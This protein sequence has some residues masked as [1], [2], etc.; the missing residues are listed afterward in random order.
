MPWDGSELWVGRLDTDGSVGSTDLIAGGSIG[1][2]REP[3]LGA[4]RQ[5]RVRL[6]PDRAGGTCIAGGRARPGI[7]ALCPMEA[8]FAVPQW[9]FG[10]RQFG[11]DGRGRVVAI[12]R[13]AGRDRL[14]VLESGT[15][16][17]SIA[18]GRDRPARPV[19]GR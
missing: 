4:R 2:H 14:L 6:G 16:R 1:V 8:E 15:I 9:V 3:G 19:R 7:E 18:A 11:F 13:S 5:P 12:A 17:A 10:Q